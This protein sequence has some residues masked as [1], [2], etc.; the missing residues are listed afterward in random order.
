MY[1]YDNKIILGSALLLNVC[2]QTIL[3]KKYL[4]LEFVIHVTIQS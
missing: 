3:D 4:K 2:N 1:I